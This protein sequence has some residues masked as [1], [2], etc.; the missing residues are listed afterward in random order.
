MAPAFSHDRREMATSFRQALHGYISQSELS[1]IKKCD[2]EY[3]DYLPVLGYELLSTGPGQRLRMVS[4]VRTGSSSEAALPALLAKLLLAF[5][6][7]FEEASRL[8]LAM[9][10]NLLRLTSEEAISV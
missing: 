4:A 3:A 9:N 2:V 8:S 10:A 5:A 6:T 1:L 7:E